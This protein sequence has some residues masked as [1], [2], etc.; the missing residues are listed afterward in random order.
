MSAPE[1]TVDV[2]QFVTNLFEFQYREVTMVGATLTVLVASIVFFRVSRTSD[3][4]FSPNFQLD[5]SPY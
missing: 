2:E 5:C 1:S 4:V 3:R